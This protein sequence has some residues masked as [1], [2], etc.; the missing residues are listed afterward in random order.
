MGGQA[1]ALPS[2]TEDLKP[3][4]KMKNLAAGCH[5]SRPDLA[6]VAFHR[7]SSQQQSQHRATASL[8]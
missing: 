6:L 7:N 2:S 8:Q 3:T 5:L 1:S 4:P